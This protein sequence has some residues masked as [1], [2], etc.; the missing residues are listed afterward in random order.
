MKDVKFISYERAGTKKHSEALRRI[1]LISNPDPTRVS[2]V[3]WEV[4]VGE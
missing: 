4:W 1:K 2:A 3:A